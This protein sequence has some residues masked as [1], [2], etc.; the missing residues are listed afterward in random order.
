MI[1]RPNRSRWRSRGLRAAG[2]VVVL[3]SAVVAAFVEH[4][5]RQAAGG[6]RPGDRRAAGL[7]GAGPRSAMPPW[8]STPSNTPDP[9]L[10]Y[11]PA[12]RIHPPP[13]EAIPVLPK[14]APPRDPQTTPMEELNPGGVNGPRPP[15]DN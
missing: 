2:L 9:G 6:E 10:G 4:A 14:L 3:L 8:A 1:P 5:H 15:R 13:P 7:A 12:W 11:I